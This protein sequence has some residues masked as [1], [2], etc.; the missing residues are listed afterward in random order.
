MVQ[1]SV[2]TDELINAMGNRFAN[3]TPTY[4][5][6]ASF[7]AGILA[8]TPSA[9]STSLT[10][11]APLT[12]TAVDDCEATTGWSASTDG[13]VALNTTSGEFIEGSG[14]LNLVKSGTTQTAVT[15]SKTT[16]SVD[17]TSKELWVWLYIADLTNFATT[18]CVQIRFG[19]D[20][21]NYY[22]Y[23]V[24]KADLVVGPNW[25]YFSSATATGTTGSPVIA[26]CD[27]TAIVI[28]TSATSGTYTGN[29]VRIDHLQVVTAANMSSTFYSGP[30][31]NTATD[32]VTSIVRVGVGDAIG[33]PLTNSGWF[34]STGEMYGIDQYTADTKTQ[35]EE[36]EYTDGVQLVSLP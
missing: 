33:Q 12:F 3:G 9:G 6:P 32:V 30:T 18:S 21:S 36:F 15:F 13:S 5:I 22:S 35:E 7:Q 24:N 31:Q 4:G 20:S 29:S 26:S 27:Y 23:T 16:T 19:S 25:L 10:R 34:L 17:F 14:C 2:S 28:T 11:K 1:V 8:Q